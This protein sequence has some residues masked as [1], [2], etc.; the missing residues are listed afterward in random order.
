[1]EKRKPHYNLGEI[2]AALG[3]ATTLNRTVTAADGA[4]DLG[5]SDEGVASVIRSLSRKDFYKSMTAMHNSRLWQDVYLPKVAGKKLYVKF[6][7][8][9]EDNYLLISFKDSES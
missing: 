7:K 2:Q 8:D 3:D 5:L 9:A 4:A 1:M 6:T